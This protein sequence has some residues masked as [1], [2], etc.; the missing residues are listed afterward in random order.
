MPRRI[1]I[2]ERGKRANRAEARACLLYVPSPTQDVLPSFSRGAHVVDN[3]P[4]VSSQPRLFRRKV[5][6]LLTVPVRE[7]HRELS[8][9]RAREEIRRLQEAFDEVDMR[10]GGDHDGRL[11]EF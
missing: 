8:P 6:H 9:G 2:R 11:E 1:E 4:H 10:H 7:R 3:H 5:P